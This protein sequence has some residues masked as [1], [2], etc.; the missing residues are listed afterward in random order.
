MNPSRISKLFARCRAEN[1]PAL[2][3]YITAGDP[4]LERTVSLVQAMELGGADLIELGVPFSDPIAD[5]PV[6]MRATERALA[7][8][9]SVAG[10]L[11]V[12]RKIRERSEIPILLFS[13]L[14][15]LLRYG[16][17]RLAKDAVAAGVDGILMTDASVE[18]AGKFVPVVREAGLDTVFLAAPTSPIE[19]LR[20]VAAYS[21]GF[22]YLVSRTGV[23]GVRDQ[24]ADSA[25][26]LVAR[27]RT[28]TDLP[29]AVGFGIAQAADAAAVAKMADGVVVGSAFV[30]IIEACD[31]SPEIESKL[32]SFTRELKTGARAG[33]T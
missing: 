28:V 25:A 9:A 18:E 27:M 19:R 24:V 15:P 3:A 30:R 17:E 14:N 32:E 21:S 4:S 12:A 5:G 8:G 2:I 11:E 7:N 23:T 6:I 1:E 29:L 33:R 10:V 16:F 31:G 13:Y 26:E 20:Q 22:I